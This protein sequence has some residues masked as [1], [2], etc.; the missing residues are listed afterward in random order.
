ME[1]YK[2]PLVWQMYGHC[3]IEANSLEE[4]VEIALGPDTPLP[5]GLYVDGSAAIDYEVL[6]LNQT[7]KETNNLERKV[8]EILI[9]TAQ[10]LK[11]LAPDSIDY[12]I[13]VEELSDCAFLL[14]HGCDSAS[15]GEIINSTTSKELHKALN[16]MRKFTVTIE[17][18]IGQA[19]TVYA[20]GLEDAIKIAGDSYNRGE[21]VVEPK[22]PTARL[23]MAVDDSSGMETEWKAF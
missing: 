6:E 21:F 7:R 17:E 10:R 15:I 12:P 5:D 13:A 16:S 9:S 4:A 23:M 1:T 2:I 20:S 3:N 19:F 8:L 22:T 11:T 18:H 14:G